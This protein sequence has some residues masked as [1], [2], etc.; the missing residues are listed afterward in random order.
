MKIVVYID[1]F[2]LLNSIINFIILY[3]ERTVFHLNSAWYRLVAGSIVGGGG[4]VIA[5]IYQQI[6][7]FL[8]GVI[9]YGVISPLLIIVSFG[10]GNIRKLLTRVIAF[11][12]ISFFIGGLF[13]FFT[14]Q[15]NQ[16][17]WILMVEG[18]SKMTERLTIQKVAIIFIL[19]LLTMPIW[20]FLLQKGKQIKDQ[21]YQ[22][23]LVH[24]EKKITIVGLYD[25]GN[26]LR[27]WLTKKPVAVV[28]SEQ[29]KHL[30]NEDEKMRITTYMQ[31]GLEKEEKIFKEGKSTIRLTII[32]YH[33]IGQS[34]GMMVGI[35]LDNV[36]IKKGM[37]QKENPNTIVA[38]YNGKISASEEYRMILHRELVENLEL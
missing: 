26:C 9:L 38:L 7:L 31:A 12:G 29:I 2:F 19:I 4:A 14:Q 37:K 32:P 30:L 27:H 24:N 10:Y 36:I 8:K 13:S 3:C 28:E 22:V 23:Q 25:T 5:V 16:W 11:Y 18:E 35:Y 15:L 17:S 34:H 6:P 33:S 20:Y 21:Y 1:I